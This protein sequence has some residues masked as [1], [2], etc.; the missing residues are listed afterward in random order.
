MSEADVLVLRDQKEPKHRSKSRTHL[1]LVDAGTPGRSNGGMWPSSEATVSDANFTLTKHKNRC[2]GRLPAGLLKHLAHATRLQR[3]T[4]PS[5]DFNLD[6]VV[7]LRREAKHI[8]ERRA[9]RRRPPTRVAEIGNNIGPEE[10]FPPTLDLERGEEPLHLDITMPNVHFAKLTRA[11]QGESL[12]K[13]QTRLV[14]KTTRDDLGNVG[15][16][17][18]ESFGKALR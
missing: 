8:I 3:P 17:R 1:S 9:S 13:H 12:G 11:R 4:L 15:K 5:V 18:A 7:I 6:H 2:L 10:R 16:V 14:M